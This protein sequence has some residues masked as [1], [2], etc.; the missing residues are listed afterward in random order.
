MVAV[1]DGAVDAPV[2]KRNARFNPAEVALRLRIEE[3]KQVRI[4]EAS[5]RAGKH[6]HPPCRGIGLFRLYGFWD[7]LERGGAGLG[8]EPHRPSVGAQGGFVKCQVAVVS[9]TDSHQR[10]AL[11]VAFGELFRPYVVPFSVVEP[12]RK[13]PGEIKAGPFGQ[14]SRLQAGEAERSTVVIDADLEC[15]RAKGGEVHG[16]VPAVV[17]VGD[18]GTFA[19]QGPPLLTDANRLSL[20]A[21]AGHLDGGFLP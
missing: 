9:R 2:P 4:H 7:D 16:E 3:L 13:V 12:C 1:P 14:A 20:R 17:A 11:P 19:P 21:D 5:G 18:D 8:A 15:G 6:E 10:Q